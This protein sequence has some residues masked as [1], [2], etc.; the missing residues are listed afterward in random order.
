MISLVCKD[1]GCKCQTQLVDKQKTTI[2]SACG[3][4]NFRRDVLKG[5]VNNKACKH[6]YGFNPGIHCE[7][8]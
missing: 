8:A 2:C 5:I 6:C 3:G 7:A 1:C 4:T